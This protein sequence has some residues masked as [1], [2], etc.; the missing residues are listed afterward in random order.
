MKLEI[1]DIFQVVL[2]KI[3]PKDNINK[4]VENTIKILQDSINK[5]DVDAIIKLG[6]SFSKDTYLEGDFDCDLFVRFN[7]IKYQNKDISEILEQLIPF[8][9]EK[10][11]GSRDYFQA[12]I[13]NVNYEIVPVLNIKYMHQA[14]NVTDSSPLHVNWFIKANN[15][16]YND[17]IRLAKCFCK[18]NRLYGAESHIK[19]FSGH[20]LDILTIY[21]GGFENLLKHS[22]DWTTDHIV[23]ISKHYE[24]NLNISKISPLIVI[25]PIQPERNAAAALSK[26]KIVE[27]QKLASE[28]L[29]NP[30]MD[31]FIKKAIDEEELKACGTLFKLKIIPPTGKNDIVGSKILKVHE[32]IQNQAKLNDFNIDKSEWDYDSKVSY[33]YY[34][35]KKTE[36]EEVKVI[37]G[38]PIKVKVHAENFKTIHKDAFEQEG[39]LYANVKRKYTQFTNFINEILSDDY[40]TQKLKFIE[41]VKNN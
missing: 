20:V 2:E 1:N 18:A 27:F 30:S 33:L 40:I 36:L 21:Y 41:V 24:G 3:K 12:V 16:Q 23:D 22:K 6:G 11:H 28:F 8:K 5:N 35:L 9:F 13:D 37:K 7:F 34:I 31:F 10:V 39:F 17:Q 14:R 25:D 19:G 32:Y 15:N 4:K 26:E 29:D 38:P